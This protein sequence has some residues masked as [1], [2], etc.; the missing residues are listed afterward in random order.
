MTDKPH[1]PLNVHGE[2]RAF[3]GRRSGKR[4]HKGQDRLYAELLPALEIPLP[5]GSLD[6][7]GLFPGRPR[8]AIEIGYGGGEHLARLAGENPATGYIGCEVFSG[9]IAKLLETV[10]ARELANVRLFTDDALK[11]L[12]KLPPASLDAAYLLY[13]DPWPKTRHHKRR[14][15][16]PQTLG[17]LA[18]VLKPGAVF[19]FATDIEDYANWTLAHIIRSPDF[20]FAPARPGIW[21]EPYPGWQP[22][23]YEDKARHEGRM[24]SFYLEFHRL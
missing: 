18:R 7:D 17:E 5:E 24:T 21:H 11:L 9:G 15:I 8:R 12:V 6:L 22:T 20:R 1:H 3:F 4:L 10:D 14:F 2:P 13:P 19:R 16:S 23:R